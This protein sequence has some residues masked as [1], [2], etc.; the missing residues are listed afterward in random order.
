MRSFVDRSNV[1]EAVVDTGRFLVLGPKGTGKSALAWYLRE[2]GAERKL[3]VEARDASELPILE[4]ASLKTGE[5]PGLSRSLNAWRFVILCAL[6][7]VIL[8]DPNSKLNSNQEA[9]D[10]IDKLRDFGFLDSTPRDAILKASRI[11]WKVPVP[12]IGRIFDREAVT[13]LH[14]INL[15]PYMEEWI[16]QEGADRQRHY[17]ILDGLDSIYLNDPQYIPAISSLV[18]SALVINQKLKR[19]G[20]GA[21]V[22]VL[23]RNDVFS[24]LD[25]PDGGKIR[26]DWAIEL[27]WRELSG[28]SRS[29]PL[30]RLVNQKAVSLSDISPFDVVQNFF[31]SEI[32]LGRNGAE[33]ETY[34]YLL[35]LTRHTP[36]DLLR[37]LEHIRQVGEAN[38]DIDPSGMLSTATIREGVLQ[39]ATKYFVDAIRNELVGRG[40]SGHVGRVVVDALRDVN[41]RRFNRETFATSLAEQGEGLSGVPNPSEALRWLFFAGAIGNEVGGGVNSYLQFFHR[42]DDNNIHLGGK[43]VLHNALVHAWALPWG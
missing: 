2:T 11:T 33:R 37:L 10:V 43:L 23:L 20:G 30:F 19:K 8:R 15:M 25:L 21:G 22:I 5:G 34:G 4:I 1:V 28:N 13:S 12:A 32:E 36:R 39:Y 24:R 40:M 7:D 26:A 35:N 18:Q 41:S 17:V 29:A 3:V 9:L 42:R 27:D 38:H 31:P 6:L 16:A 14:L